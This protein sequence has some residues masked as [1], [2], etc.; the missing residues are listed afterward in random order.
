MKNFGE[1]LLELRT[2]KG[3]SQKDLLL[4]LED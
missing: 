4:G 1:R 3:L 2:E